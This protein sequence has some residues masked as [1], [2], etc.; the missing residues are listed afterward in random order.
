MFRLMLVCRLHRVG[1]GARSRKLVDAANRQ[2][3]LIT[4]LITTNEIVNLGD[5]DAGVTEADLTGRSGAVKLLKMLSMRVAIRQ[6]L[7]DT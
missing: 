6:V 5:P 4:L 1:I 7:D 2:A 3:T